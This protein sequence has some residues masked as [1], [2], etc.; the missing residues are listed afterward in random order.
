MLIARWIAIFFHNL[1][2]L[3]RLLQTGIGLQ[4]YR[5]HHSEKACLRN[6]RSERL[7]LSVIVTARVASGV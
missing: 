1:R 7:A 6:Q 5:T 2:H 4:P 3:R